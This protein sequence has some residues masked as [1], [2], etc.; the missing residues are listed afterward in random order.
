MSFNGATVAQSNE[1][2]ANCLLAGRGFCFLGEFHRSDYS[3]KETLSM[4]RSTL[5]AV[6]GLERL[7]L[8][9]TIVDMSAFAGDIEHGPHGRRSMLLCHKICMHMAVRM[10]AAPQLPY[11]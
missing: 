5:G 3:F 6:A 7:V 4:Q 9:S 11:T 1:S 10:G 2:K 8:V